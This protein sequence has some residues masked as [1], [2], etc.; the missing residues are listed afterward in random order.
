METVFDNQQLIATF[1]CAQLVKMEEGMILRGG[2][3]SDRLEAL[4]WISLFLPE[5][6]ATVE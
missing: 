3:S 6:F 5:E 4:E 1:G 2:S